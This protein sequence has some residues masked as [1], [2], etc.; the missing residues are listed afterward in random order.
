MEYELLIV[1]KANELVGYV[2][3]KVGLPKL[4]STN[5]YT[6]AQKDEAVEDLMDLNRRAMLREF[7]PVPTDPE[8]VKLIEDPDFAPVE[9]DEVDVPDL[10]NSKVVY[11]MKPGPAQI[12]PA[13]GLVSSFAADEIKYDDAGLPIIN[14]MA[15]EIVYKKELQPKRTN[16]KSRIEKACEA[17]AE[18]RMGGERIERF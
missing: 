8:V 11:D 14:W 7:W 1:G 5:I 10:E 2:I 9:Y 16:G 12:D 17:V 13:T 18:R 4:E 3:R 15:S 6:T